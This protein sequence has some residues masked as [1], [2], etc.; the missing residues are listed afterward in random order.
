MTS[1][2]TTLPIDRL[3]INTLIEQKGLKKYWLAEEIGITSGT[4]SRWLN[5]RI[6]KVKE[7]H[8]KEL[9]KLLECDLEELIDDQME[10]FFKASDQRTAAE[11]I[12]EQDLL[13]DMARSSHWQLFLSVLRS[14]LNPYLPAKAKGRMYNLMSIAYWYVDK[15][16]QAF[17]FAKKA[18]QL[19]HELSER[20]IIDRANL[21]LGGYSYNC[22]DLEKGRTQILEA[23]EGD[24]ALSIR[25]RYMAKILL[26]YHWFYIG[27]F[28]K[29]LRFLKENESFMNDGPAFMM[30]NIMLNVNAT[31][32]AEC[33]LHLEQKETATKAMNLI[34]KTNVL[35]HYDL[36]KTLLP[37]IKAWYKALDNQPDY[38][39]DQWSKEK[40][41][42][43]PNLY[44]AKIYLV[45]AR[46]FRIIKDYQTSSEIIKIG[47]PLV[48]NLPLLKA[49]FLFERLEIEQTMSASN[50]QETYDLLQKIYQN[51][52]ATVRLSRL[53]KSFL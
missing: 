29:C 19:G 20:A 15:E 36:G 22:G 42:V 7:E 34:S 38:V 12:D 23:L 32:I 10:D 27:D 13:S 47:L 26:C 41:S 35:E 37:C 24:T 16:K 40:I 4:F 14:T 17:K 11:L 18:L 21:T 30:K 1:K 44:K 50:G 31:F 53:H 33:A 39:K 25:D 49:E 5:G 48:E 43:K 3:K 52:G 8:L 6:T 46:A 9:A 28:E 45:W 2:Y 51:C